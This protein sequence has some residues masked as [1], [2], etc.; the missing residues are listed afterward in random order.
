MPCKRQCQQKQKCR[1]IYI[2]YLYISTVYVF[3]YTNCTVLYNVCCS[4]LEL[5]SGGLG[6]S[7]SLL[8]SMS[9]LSSTCRLVETGLFDADW[10]ILTSIL[11]MVE[12]NI[13]LQDQNICSCTFTARCSVILGHKATQSFPTC[14]LGLHILSNEWQCLSQSRIVSTNERRGVDQKLNLSTLCIVESI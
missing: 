8:S 2:Q 1:S 6:S 9:L 5:S 4:C 13:L 14:A 7:A 3:E 10:L 12:A 11:R